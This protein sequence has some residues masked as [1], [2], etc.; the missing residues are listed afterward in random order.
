MSGRRQRT[1]EQRSLKWPLLAFVARTGECRRRV[2]CERIFSLSGG[3]VGIP[4]P[5]AV[6]GNHCCTYAQ[7]NANDSDDDDSMLEDAEESDQIEENGI[8]LK[9]GDD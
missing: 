5:P 1:C 3:L 8:D 4:S 7:S 6:H 9:Y 2:I